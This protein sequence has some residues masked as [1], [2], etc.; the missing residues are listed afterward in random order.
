M[1]SVTLATGAILLVYLIQP[2]KNKWPDSAHP[3][4][5]SLSADRMAAAAGA[6]ASP[7]CEQRRDLPFQRGYVDPARIPA[8]LI[9]L[10]VWRESTALPGRG[11]DVIRGRQR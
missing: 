4:P 1:A 7:G 11:G 9:K 2:L 5:V 10:G 6:Q 3:S 8:A